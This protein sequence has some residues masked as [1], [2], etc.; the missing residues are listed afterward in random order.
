MN[1]TIALVAICSLQ[2]FGAACTKPSDESCRAAIENMRSILGT[3]NIHG[4]IESDIRRCSTG[5]SKQAV[6]CAIK[7]T[8]R[9]ELEACHLVKREPPKPTPDP[10]SGK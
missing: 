2:L 1:R 5:S 7:A 4:D 8:S 10:G 9:A 6:E 3:E